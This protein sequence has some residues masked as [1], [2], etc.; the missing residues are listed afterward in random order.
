MNSLIGLPFREARDA[1]LLRISTGPSTLR[2]TLLNVEVLHAIDHISGQA[3]HLSMS[4]YA[5][6][7]GDLIKELG[8]NEAAMSK[9]RQALLPSLKLIASTSKMMSASAITAMKTLVEAACRNEDKVV[10]LR[11]LVSG[12]EKQRCSLGDSNPLVY[13]SLWALKDLLNTLRMLPGMQ[14]VTPKVYLRAIQLSLDGKPGID[15]VAVRTY[16]AGDRPYV[17]DYLELRPRVREMRKLTGGAIAAVVKQRA[18]FLESG[19]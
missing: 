2:H 1:V 3:T 19:K 13:L 18:D 7:V 6:L 10:L 4:T 15:N 12:L 5:Q 8:G 16:N 17:Q 14:T 9:L 11:I